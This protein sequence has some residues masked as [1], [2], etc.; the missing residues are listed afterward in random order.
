MGES[1]QDYPRLVEFL[2]YWERKRG[3]LAMPRRRDI[4]PAEIPHLLPFIQMLDVVDSGRRY[5][6]RL[7]GTAIVD[8]FGTDTTGKHTDETA[9]GDR[10]AFVREFYD[11]VRTSRR[12]A[13]VRSRYRT[14]RGLDITASRLVT[15][16]SE[17]GS[18][19][20]QI[21]AAICFEYRSPLPTA[22]M[23]EDEVDRASSAI[24]VL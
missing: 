3:A 11:T 2:G 24:T 13:F 9:S 16:L 6:Y 10:R 7:V 14:A 18:T 22:I 8:A 20:T 15:P 17:D 12:P 5:R 4:D 1:Y 19:V 21:I 23:P